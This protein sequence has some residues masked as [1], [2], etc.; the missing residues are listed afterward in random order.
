MMFTFFVKDY[1]MFKESL[2]SLCKLQCLFVFVKL[3]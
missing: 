2:K 1:N 3:F